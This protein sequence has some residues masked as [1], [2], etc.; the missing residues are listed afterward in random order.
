MYAGRPSFESINT[1][2]LIDMQMNE[3]P[4]RLS[5]YRPEITSP[6]EATLLRALAKNPEERPTAHEIAITLR[7]ELD[8]P[9]GTTGTHAR[10]APKIG[11]KIV[12]PLAPDEPSRTM[13]R[14]RKPAAVAT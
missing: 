8:V 1:M 7:E 10:S 9:L 11:P 2:A 5:S 6:I 4:P 14:A 12:L 3:P 13:L